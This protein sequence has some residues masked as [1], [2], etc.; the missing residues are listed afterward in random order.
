M[1]VMF[2]KAV[3]WTLIL[4][5]L[6]GASAPAVLAACGGSPSGGSGPPS[7]SATEISTSQALE[8]LRKRREESVQTA[9]LPPVALPTS[10][11]T[12]AAPAAPA[13]P[14]AVS[15]AAPVSATPA[16][17]A[18]AAGPTQVAPAAAA[19]VAPSVVIATPAP[20]PAG[21]APAQLAASAPVV[22]ANPAP[23]LTVVS[24]AR[25]VTPGIA[26]PSIPPQ[27][28]PAPQ[29]MAA[30]E[31]VRPGVVMRAPQRPSKDPIPA[32][33]NRSAPV[34][35]ASVQNAAP[36]QPVR[37]IPRRGSWGE[38]FGDVER[39][40]GLTYDGGT[41]GGLRSSR[42]TAGFVSGTDW[43]VTP[44]DASRQIILGLMSSSFQG[45]TRFN[46][47]TYVTPDP[48]NAG[49]FDI[50]A[51]QD[52]REVAAGMGVG[53]YALAS[54]ERWSFDAMARADRVEVEQRDTTRL[55]GQIVGGFESPCGV[56]APVDRSAHVDYLAFVVAANFNLRQKLGTT[57]TLEPT[58]GFRATFID[59]ERPTG[60]LPLAVQDGSILRLQAGAR[61]IDSRLLASG[62]RASLTLTGLLYSDVRIDG[63]TPINSVG[64][65]PS[66]V[67]E[68]KLRAL[69]SIGYSLARQDGWTFT[70][71]G[72][73]RGGEHVV[74]AAG[75]LSLRYEW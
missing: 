4:S 36:H 39:E 35:R 21:T 64:F 3:C 59:Y 6:Q 69:A 20:G 29:R 67:N 72:E 8:L 25:P 18:P 44:S 34:A 30:A 56:P 55:I 57:S 19:P 73:V 74:G 51:R 43:R 58:I 11:V 16:P 65:N 71:Q 50:I 13:L 24:P 61:L 42:V 38:V 7:I 5:L 66:A 14:A 49:D 10:V 75:K 1:R 40:S 15:V 48:V 32:S 33:N 9:A 47:L 22:V 23:T 70:A 26:T 31:T 45:R 46:D 63:L 53:T 62:E 52:A 28:Q 2:Y 27:G 37:P 60:T 12:T 54:T 68:G 17:V 41:I